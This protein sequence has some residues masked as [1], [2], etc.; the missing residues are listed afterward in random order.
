MAYNSITTWKP[1]IFRGTATTLER[2]K[3]FLL[4]TKG[5]K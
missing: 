3:V 2:Y 5:R 4:I 1:Y